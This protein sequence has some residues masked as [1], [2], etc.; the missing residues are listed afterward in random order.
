MGRRIAI[1]LGHP[2]IGPTYCRALAHA[3]AEGA[4][5]QG[6][7][8]RKIDVASLDF[9]ILRSARHFKEGE[10]P[11]A[12]RTAQ[13]AI[14]W[15]EH[16]LIVYPLWLGTMP[17]LLKAFFEQCFR[18][19]FALDYEGESNW[20]RGLLKGR[21]ARVVITMGMPALAYR[22]YYGAH[23]LKS[24]ERNVLKFCGISPVRETLIGGIDGL[25]EGKRRRWLS[26]LCSLGADAA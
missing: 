22:W 21:S 19:G 15:A 25:S 14:G 10:A 18:P 24:L 16:L 17:A 7:E 3:Y 4:E 26:R 8:V 1:I 23:S 6:H 9:P 20:P 12:I 5:K 2:D 11:E 13:E